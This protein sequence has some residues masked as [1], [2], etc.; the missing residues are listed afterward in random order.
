MIQVAGIVTSGATVWEDGGQECHVWKPPP[1][2]M[3]S[4]RPMLLLQWRGRGQK[5]KV[6]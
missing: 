1:S 6:I 3:K 2:L 4:I 5:N